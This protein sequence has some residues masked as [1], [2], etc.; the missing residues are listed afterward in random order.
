MAISLT[1]NIKGREETLY[2]K[3]KNVSGNKRAM[4]ADIAYFW[5]KDAACDTKIEME[6]EKET[7]PF[8]PDH[9]GVWSSAYTEIKRRLELKGYTN[10]QDIVDPEDEIDLADIPMDSDT[11]PAL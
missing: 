10:I 1:R 7:I 8:K 3:I 5:D 4:W 2:V 6:L 9:S 11:T